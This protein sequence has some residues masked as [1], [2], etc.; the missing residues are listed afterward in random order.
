PEYR[1]RTDMKQAVGAGMRALVCLPI[2]SAGRIIGGFCLASKRPGI[3]G[4]ATREMLEQL[5]LEQA[6]LPLLNAI[7]TAERDFVN[8]LVKKI[9]GAQDMQR[10]AETV[11]AEIA[12]FYEFQNVSI[13]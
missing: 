12:S 8:A 5:L 4:A 9:A 10:V 2:R 11:V 7:D 6:F 3:Y 1:E 13:F